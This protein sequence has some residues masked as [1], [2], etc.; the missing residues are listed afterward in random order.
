M[1]SGSMATAAG[2]W[3]RTV[4]RPV[5]P[6]SV[7][8]MQRMTARNR[9]RRAVIMPP[10]AESRM[11][12]RQIPKPKPQIPTK[13]P[14]P[15]SQARPFVSVGFFVAVRLGV[16][17]WDL[18]GIWRLGFVWDLGSGRRDY[19]PP[20]TAVRLEITINHEGREPA[21]PGVRRSGWPDIDRR[22]GRHVDDT[23]DLLQLALQPGGAGTADRRDLIVHLAH[24]EPG[25]LEIFRDVS[26][27]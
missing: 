7:P 10:P 25:A 11:L 14:I 8:A 21:L 27:R 15:N 6:A 16:G 4:T 17:F 13:V 3:A 26:D 23:L 2:C 22:V 24:G 18:V 20:R 9:G 19:E 1:S 5:T 12:S